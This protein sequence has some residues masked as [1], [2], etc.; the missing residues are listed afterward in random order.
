MKAYIGIDPGVSGAIAILKEGEVINI[1]HDKATDKEIV[2]F[3]TRNLKDCNEVIAVLEKVHSMPGQG[4][5]STF[6]FGESYG[7]SQ[8]ILSTLGV[9]YE[10]AVPRTWQKVLG[11]LKR[12]KKESKTDFKRRLKQKAEQLFPNVK[13]V[14]NNADAL[15]I[16]EYC[17]RIHKNN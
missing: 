1:R 14:N 8:G 17:R 11:I 2:E 7:K 6:K 5:K 9:P 3:Y 13:I 16:A 15:L 4:V 12:D 10:F